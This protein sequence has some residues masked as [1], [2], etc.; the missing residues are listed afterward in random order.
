MPGVAHRSSERVKVKKKRLVISLLIASL[1]IACSQGTPDGAGNANQSSGNPFNPISQQSMRGDIER[2]SF[3]VA[4]AI[5]NVRDKK[6]ADA[7]TS[8]EGARRDI[9]SALSGRAASDR[10][11]FLRPELEGLKS[12]I[13]QTTE[14]VQN[15]SADADGL[16]TQLQVQINVIRAH[17]QAAETSAQPQ[18]PKQ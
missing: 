18:Q 7:V 15:R 1:F 14:A 10:M 12:S 8:L 6:W 4:T 5:N 16:L 13:A 11:Q 2:A 3:A 17:A 9:D